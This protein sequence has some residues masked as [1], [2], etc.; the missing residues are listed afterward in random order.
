LTDPV[1]PQG[2][3]D[4]ANVVDRS[5]D[6]FC[7]VLENFIAGNRGNTVLD[8][9]PYPPPIDEGGRLPLSG[10]CLKLA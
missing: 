5:P 9:G 3:A 1:Y 10:H 4:T 2:A 7:G 8:E 6:F